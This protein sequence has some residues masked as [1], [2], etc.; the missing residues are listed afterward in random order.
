MIKTIFTL[1]IVLLGVSLINAQ[2]FVE[3]AFN[4]RRVINSHSVEMLEKGIM[5]FRVYH[6]FGDLAGSQG[7]WQNFYGL[8]NSADVGFGFD[9]GI[10]DNINIGI[11]R[12]KGTGDLRQN[13]NTF[14]K[15]RFMRQQKDGRNPLSI[16][17]LTV[18]N[19]STMPK[20]TT[21]GV[22]S[23]FPEFSNRL[24]YHTQLM[25]ARRFSDRVSA[26]LNLNYTYRDIVY[27]Y[28]QNDIV[29]VGLSARVR[30]TKATALIFDGT[31]PLLDGQRETPEQYYLPLSF[32]VEFETGGGHV[33]QLNLTNSKGISETDYIPYSFSNWADGEFRMG[34]TIARKFTVR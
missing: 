19:I 6:R 7:G 24:A 25:F 26:Q 31:Y 32:G 14:A 30:I 9:Y 10:N 13:I 22:L 29:S 18:A 16:T 8:E 20:N 17:A 3:E 12:T 1:V 27:T 34:F 11:A 4:D 15:F 23:F 21:P 5:D 33:F 2:E 28:D